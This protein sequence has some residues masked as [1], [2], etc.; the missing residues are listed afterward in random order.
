MVLIKTKT[1]NKNKLRVITSL[2]FYILAFTSF[3]LVLTYLIKENTRG[4]TRYELKRTVYN[5]NIKEN[6]IGEPYSATISFKGNSK[7]Y[8]HEPLC[9]IDWN[10]PNQKKKR[11][12][13]D[14]KP[15]KTD[16]RQYL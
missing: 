9:V 2:Q 13:N 16:L 6:L 15:N 14:N 1:E 8:P 10:S 4:N 12:K 11:K 3:A 5:G 7:L